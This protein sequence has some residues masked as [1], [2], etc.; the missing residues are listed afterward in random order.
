MHQLSRQQRSLQEYRSRKSLDVISIV[1][2]KIQG[3]MR[4]RKVV[5]RV[6]TAH[7]FGSIGESLLLTNFAKQWRLE[8]KRCLRVRDVWPEFRHLIY[9]EMTITRQDYFMV[10]EEDLGQTLDENSEDDDDREL[11][12]S[13]SHGLR[14]RV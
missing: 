1:S 4:T 11:T 14:Q 6:F 5:M 13:L 8:F 3:A 2:D 12:A 7:V 10:S 9:I